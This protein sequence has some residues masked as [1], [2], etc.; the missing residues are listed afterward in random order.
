ML[1]K[2]QPRLTPAS[3]NKSDSDLCVP[4]TPTSTNTCTPD[5]LPSPHTDVVCERMK[6]NAE[7]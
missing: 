1:K 6:F 3:P 2:T 4:G 7:L 5:P